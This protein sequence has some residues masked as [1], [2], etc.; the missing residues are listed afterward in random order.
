MV[1]ETPN[2]MDMVFNEVGD[3]VVKVTYDSGLAAAE[4][5]VFF[6]LRGAPADVELSVQAVVTDV[7]GRAAVRV[8]S[9]ATRTSFDVL[10]KSPNDATDLELPVMVVV[11]GVY[12]GDLVVGYE[13]LD[14]IPTSDIVTRVHEGALD[15]TRITA[16]ALPEIM[17]E[18]TAATATATTRFA[19]LVETNFYTVTAVAMGPAGSPVAFG[20]AISPEIRGREAGYNDCRPLTV[21]TGYRWGIHLRN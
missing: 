1:V 18:A 6:S 9:G 5:P 8:S 20:C 11:D 2:P 14:S 12:R 16:S 13:E 4:R 21:P 7:N 15:C 19:R 3:L 17:D 10:A